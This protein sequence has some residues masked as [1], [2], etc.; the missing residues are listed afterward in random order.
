VALRARPACVD[1]SARPSVPC[2]PTKLLVPSQRWSFNAGVSA[3]AQAFVEHVYWAVYC[4]GW[5]CDNWIFLADAG[6]GNPRHDYKFKGPHRI[7]V[8]CPACKTAAVYNKKEI[9]PI[10]AQAPPDEWVNHPALQA[11]DGTLVPA[12]AA[13]THVSFASRL[14][15]VVRS[16]AKV[17][18]KQ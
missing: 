2:V 3:R 8:T 4:R 11:V 9:K 1:Q 14:F 17:L 7:H 6:P 15:P 13:R 5:S 10:R 18:L 16:A 12:N